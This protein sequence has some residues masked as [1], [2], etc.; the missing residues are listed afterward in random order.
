MSRGLLPGWKNT[1]VLILTIFI[2]MLQLVSGIKKG[3]MQLV[4]GNGGY[5]PR[6]EENDVASFPQ[7]YVENTPK[8]AGTIKAA[9]L[10]IS[11]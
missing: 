7:I 1:P 3:T 2:H 5:S 6:E 11:P 9:F 8:T 4:S 10:L